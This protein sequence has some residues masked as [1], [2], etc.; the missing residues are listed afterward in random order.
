MNGNNTSQYPRYSL[1]AKVIIV[2]FY[3]LSGPCEPRSQMGKLGHRSQ[4]RQNVYK[5][6][7]MGHMVMATNPEP[8]WLR[9]TP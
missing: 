7:H 4:S 3:Y 2:D 6:V 9:C 5:K 8:H 1:A